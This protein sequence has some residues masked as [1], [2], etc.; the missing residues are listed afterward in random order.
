VEEEEEKEEG[1]AGGGDDGDEGG[2][3]SR[4]WE[5]MVGEVSSI[6]V[7]RT[8]DAHRLRIEKRVLVGIIGR[9]LLASRAFSLP[10]YRTWPRGS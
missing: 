3:F 5:L 2:E 1:S 9:V 8:F 4:L 7:T 10:L 6:R